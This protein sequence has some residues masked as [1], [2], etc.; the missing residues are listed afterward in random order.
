[1]DERLRR[2]LDRIAEAYREILGEKLTGLYVHGSAAFGCFR[3]ENSDVDF[4][5]V[6][7][8][9]VTMAEKERLLAWIL[10]AQPDCP[11]KGLEMSVVEERFCRAFVYPTPY[12]FHF[13]NDHLERCRQDPPAYCA[14]MHGTD[15]DLAA[16]FT[17]TRAVGFPLYGPP[18]AEMFA[19]VPAGDYLASLFYDAENMEEEITENPVYCILNLCRVLAF[20]REGAVLSKADGGIW[21]LAHL[22]PVWHD[23]IRQAAD[24]YTKGTPV[25]ASSAALRRFAAQHVGKIRSKM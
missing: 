2:L 23:I 20:C 11:P 13:S 19:P 25:Q 24:A 9:D 5:A 21:G 8:E 12:L 1:M 22:E 4:L 3:W 7:R 6:V 18:A 14:D 15:P 17:V 10:A 16:H